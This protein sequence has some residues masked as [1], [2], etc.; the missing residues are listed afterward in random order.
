MV[1]KSQLSGETKREVPRQG[2]R[3]DRLQE[4]W[5]NISNITYYIGH[6]IPEPM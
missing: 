6:N 4:D 2:W 1:T 5:P 3:V